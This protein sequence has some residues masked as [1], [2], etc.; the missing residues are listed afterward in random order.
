MA[1]HLSAEEL[2]QFSL[3]LYPKVKTQCLQLQ[4]ELNANVN[5]LLLLCLLEQR[6]LS[7]SCTQLRQ[8]SASLQRFSA[9]FTQPLRAIRQ[10][11]SSSMLTPEQQHQLKQ[12]LLQTEL[13]LEK[14]EQQL[15]LQ[16][17]PPFTDSAAPMLEPYL[18]HLSN[19]SAG[20]QQAL[21]DLRQAIAHLSQA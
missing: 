11:T 16:H 20:Y 2:W 6:Q 12:S 18:A 4:D 9:Q 15:L 17:C 14:I 13:Q 10:Q 19:N 8:L 3:R 21:F 7:L 5:L 1:K